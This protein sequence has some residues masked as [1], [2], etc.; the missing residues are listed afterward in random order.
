MAKPIKE[1]PVLKGKDAEKF[2]KQI[3]AAKGDSIDAKTMNRIQENYSK[4]SSLI[5]K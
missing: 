3:E 1:T 2:A 4:I 5:K